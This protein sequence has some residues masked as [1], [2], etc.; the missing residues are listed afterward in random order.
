VFPSRSTKEI[1][2]TF[3]ATLV[4]LDIQVEFLQVCGPLLMEVILSISLC[5]HEL[6]RPMISVDDHFLPH[7]VI[8]PL[9]TCLHNGVHI[10]VIGGVSTDNIR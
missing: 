6:Q 10:F 3:D 7:N 8:L 5:L 9:S 2:D 4:V 1:C